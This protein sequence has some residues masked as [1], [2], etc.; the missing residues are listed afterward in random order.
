M[1]GANT[2]ATAGHCVAPG[3]TGGFYDASTYTIAPGQNG[4]SQPFGTCG[5]RRLY[6]VTGWTNS[7]DEAYD[8]GAIKLK[9]A[10]GNNTGWFGFWWQG[11]SLTGLAATVTGYPGDKP[12]G[13][14]WT[15]TLSIAVTETNQIFY[16]MDT[17][18]GQS[19]SPVWKTNSDFCSGSCVMGIH[20]YGLHGASPHGDNNHGTRITEARFNNLI[21]WRDAPK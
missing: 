13:T 15:H 8:Y 2:V 5:A 16:K 12:F 1:I 14:N 17:F 10:V 18:G 21:S 3:G 7:G 11:A 6:S 4:S 9:C 20:A 19:G